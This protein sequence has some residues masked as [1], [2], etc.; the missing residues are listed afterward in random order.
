MLLTA[1]RVPAAELYRLGVIEEC[2]PAERL[3]AG[4]QAIAREMTG[5][6]VTV[7]TGAEAESAPLACRRRLRACSP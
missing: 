6:E 5:G 1:Q 2:L 3:A 7:T 4:A